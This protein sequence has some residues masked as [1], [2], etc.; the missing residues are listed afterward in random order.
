MAASP[1]WK[2]YG[3]NGEYRASCKYPED[4]GA[5]V[6]LLGDGATIRDGHRS[7]KAVWTEGV[8]GTAGDSYDDVAAAAY[9]RAGH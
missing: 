8:D 7:S 4:A 5:I 9:Q 6:A 2:V 3:A 1:R